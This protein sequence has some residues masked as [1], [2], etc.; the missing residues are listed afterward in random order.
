[1][2]QKLVLL[3][4]GLFLAAPALSQAMADCPPDQFVPVSLSVPRPCPGQPLRLRA[5]ACGPCVDLLGSAAEPMGPI[6]IRAAMDLRRCL[7]PV[8]MPES[9]TADLGT[10]APGHHELAVVIDGLITQPDGSTCRATHTQIV[11]FDGPLVCGPSPG[12]LPYVDAILIGPPPP[13]VTC[14]PPA[15]CP[16]LPI[17]FSIAGHFP[18]NC[19]EFRG[20]ELMPNPIM[21]PLPQPPIARVI[22]A[23]NDC[24]GR[25]CAQ[26]IVPWK[27][28]ALLPDLP[29]GDYRMIVE[30]AEVSWCDPANVP[31]ALHSSV[32]AF[33]V[34]QRCVVPP[35]SAEC[36]LADWRH[37]PR[38]TGCDAE[39]SPASPAKLV[40]QID[41]GPALASLQ[42]RIALLPP[43]LRVTQMRPIGAASG[44][45]LAWQVLPDGASFLMSSDHGALIPPTHPCPAFVPCGSQPVLEATVSAV[46][47]MPPPPRTL[48][49]MAELMATDALGHAVDMCPTF[50]AVDMVARICAGARVCDANSDGRMDVRDLVMMVRCLRGAASC[51]VDVNVRFDCNGDTTF[52][53]DDVLCCA[54]RILR[55]PL[56]DSLPPR[57][58]ADL[59]VELGEPVATSAGFDRSVRVSGADRLGAAR[60]ALTIP[61][62]AVL[63]G[64]E[65][66]GAPAGWMHIEEA[67][68]GQALLGLIALAPGAETEIEVLLHFSRPPAVGASSAVAIADAEFVDL[69]GQIVAPAA[70]VLGIPDGIRAR[71]ELSAARPNP[72]DL[73]TRLDLSLSAASQ[74]QLGIYDLSGRLVT[75]L[76]R[77]RLG[78][79]AHTFAWSGTRSDGTRAADGVYF[80][81]A[82][83][84]GELSARRLVLIRG[85]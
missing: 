25:P 80:C 56:P 11:A 45:R 47:G 42:G 15:I 79:G 7:L 50:A 63:S 23:V 9:L 35:P 28:H 3:T 59:R 83:A 66:P 77:G 57:S 5:D 51:P 53:A 44:M 54:R 29:P 26:V 62:D 24:Q 84:G 30:V 31:K 52:T 72:F 49:R 4:L 2:R 16:N 60:L 46:A 13:C 64:V 33:S 1:M 41:T 55:E 18:D 48:A 61:G 22:V 21:S 65:L 71:L 67:G 82:R 76:Y 19:Y 17:P 37:D 12:L 34:A 70:G 8:C 68:T 85:R 75:E 27:A 43:A 36:F 40:F 14:P 81:R 58:L 69:E 6:H 32:V 78:P 38:N 10:F 39:I 20:L 74:V 73:E